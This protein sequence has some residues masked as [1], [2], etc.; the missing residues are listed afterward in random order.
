MGFTTDD[1]NSNYYD[2]TYGDGY[3]S[4]EY[5]TD[6]MINCTNLVPAD[7]HDQ[8]IAGKAIVGSSCY[9]ACKDGYYMNSNAGSHG[10]ADN[11]MEVVCKYDWYHG[12][13]WNL[14]ADAWDKYGDCN[15]DYGSNCM[16]YPQCLPI[17]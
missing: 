10:I 1:P 13:Q 15:G 7:H 12:M 16:G 9:I 17:Q 3:P 8:W 14:Y 2:P 4:Q 5:F 11:M 6:M